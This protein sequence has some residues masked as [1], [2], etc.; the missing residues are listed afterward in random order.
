ME[1]LKNCD[2]FTEEKFNLFS[3]YFSSKID[4]YLN[5]QRT[6]LVITMEELNYNEIYPL[7]DDILKPED[8]VIFSWIQ[9]KP[10]TRLSV[11]SDTGNWN[12]SLVIPVQNFLNTTAEIYTSTSVPQRV[13]TSDITYLSY[14][15]IS[16]LESL[17]IIKPFY[18][19][20]TI[21]HTM[22]NNN[23]DFSFY[24]SIRLNKNFIL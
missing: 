13:Q 4:E 16:L 22:R 12:W 8:I 15:E 21:P 9:I 5:Y 2:V 6:N 20:N 3:E 18:M 17:P 7:V 10:N 24:V 19:N 14:N 1:Y 23:L 11:H